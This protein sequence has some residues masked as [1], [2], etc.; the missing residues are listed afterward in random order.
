MRYGSIDIGTNTILMLVADVNNGKIKRVEDYYEVPRVGKG[1]SSTR[2]LEPGSIR[3]GL[4]VL[5]RYSEIAERHQVDRIVASATSAMRD[6]INREEFIRPA[7][8]KFGIDVEVIDGETEAKLGFMGALS[9]A[10]HFDDNSLVIDIGGGSTELSYGLNTPEITQSINVGAVRI[11]ELFLRHTPPT[12]GEIGQASDFVQDALAVFPFS[13]TSPGKVFGLAGTATTLALIEQRKF[14][15][16]PEAVDNYEIS[17]ASL[18]KVFAFLRDK[19]P[20]EIG[21]LTSAAKGREDVLL[22]GCLILLKVLELAGKKSFYATDRG[23]RY[24]FL[25]YKERR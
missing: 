25:I 19:T 6:A 16:T 14:D 20:A 10:E 13:K 17:F 15:F 11:T 5:E 18:S 2:R 1:V 12:D 3:R 24:G 7:K 8:E 21:N 22:A 23:L 9:A 4:A